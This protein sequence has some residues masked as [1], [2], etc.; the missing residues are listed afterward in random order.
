[1]QEQLK[2]LTQYHGLYAYWKNKT[3]SLEKRE[4]NLIVMDLDDTLFS[5]TEQLDK[6]LLLQQNRGA[7]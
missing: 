7:K 4:N 1:M 3:N 6:E 2:K 5:R